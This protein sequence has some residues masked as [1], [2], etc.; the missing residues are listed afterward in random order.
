V[1]RC[2]DILSLCQRI[3]AEAVSG[4]AMEVLFGVKARS[5]CCR[6]TAS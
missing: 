2:V 1:Q 4:N 3:A 5:H 6:Y